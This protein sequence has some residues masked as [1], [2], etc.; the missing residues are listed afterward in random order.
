MEWYM[1]I[2]NI[3]IVL[4]SIAMIVVVVMQK[5]D[6]D[7]VGALSGAKADGMKINRGKGLEAQLPRITAI[8]GIVLAVLCLTVVIIQRFV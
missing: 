8:L 6:E 7:G 4:C 2:L 5:S 3:L 1:V